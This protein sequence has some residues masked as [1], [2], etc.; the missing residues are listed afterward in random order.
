MVY[1]LVPTLLAVVALVLLF[2][3]GRKRHYARLRHLSEALARQSL[4][5]LQLAEAARA[6]FQR[7]APGLTRIDNFLSAESFASLAHSAKDVTKPERSYVPAHKKGGTIAYETLFNQMPQ[8][9]AFYQS[10]H[11]HARIS[12]IVGTKVTATPLHDQSSCSLLCYQ[13]GGDHIGWHFDH[14]F[15]RGR[16]FTALL[17]I[18]NQGLKPCDL[19]S[20]TLV[21]KVDGQ[22]MPIE[23]P[24]NALIVFEGSKLLHKVTPIG[25]GEQRI[26]LSMTFTENPANAWYQGIAR[27][28]KDMAFF[29][30]RALWT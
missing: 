10:P 21:A 17:T 14:N 25:D 15:Y 30:I 22:A 13:R 4:G 7:V 11:L 16:H 6:R 26:V 5:G 18:V 2:V 28:A 29:G 24:P 9:V 27:R 3:I 19:S 1:S 8:I 23:T 12:E 20:A